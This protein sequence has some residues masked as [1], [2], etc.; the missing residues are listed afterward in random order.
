MD[1]NFDVVVGTPRF[2][3]ESVGEHNQPEPIYH[4]FYDLAKR[5]APRY[6]LISPARFLSKA[7]DTPKA[8]NEAML[9]DPHLKRLH[10]EQKSTVLF[11]NTDIKGGVVIL[12]RD[13]NRHLG[14]IGTFT[15]FNELHSILVKVSQKTTG[16]INTIM[17]GSKAYKLTEQAI[18][19]FPQIVELQPAWSKYVIATNAFKRLGD[20]I[21][22]ESKPGDGKEYVQIYGL[23]GTQRV[24]R[25]VR[26]DF[27]N[28]PNSFMYYKVML[29]N[30][31]G[32]GAI[33]EI[34]STPLIGEPL[35]GYTD[36][37]MSIGEFENELEA[38]NCLKYIKSKFARTMLGIL[39]V[40][41]HNSP[42]TWAKVPLQ[43]FTPSSDI[44]WT[45]S[46]P[47]IDRQLYAKYGLSAEEIAFIETKVRAM[48]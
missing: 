43:D 27:I 32:T 30:A 16:T 42:A 9:N 34:L 47:D 19:E 2:Q 4:L 44:D 24:Y 40:T 23:L 12:L 6:C 26:R 13:T 11:P 7:G 31:N 36:T 35:I 29:P 20:I 25:W 38:N 21:Y 3:D 14:P 15:T 5:L 46:I 28:S 8:W 10:F 17:T 33:G 48:E 45:R 41:Q 1:M 22:F 18:Q 39:K 37:F